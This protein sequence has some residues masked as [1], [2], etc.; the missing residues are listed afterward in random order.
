MM[1]S[2]LALAAAMTCGAPAPDG[3]M[4]LLYLECWPEMEIAGTAKPKPPAPARAADY[5]WPV[6]HVID[7]DTVAVDASA[8][9]PPELA[10]LKVRLRG[11]D[12]PETWR[13]KCEAERVAGEAATAFTERAVTGARAVL[14]RDPAWGKWG[15]RVIAE[16][17]L[18]GRA[19]S[20]ALIEAGHG[21]AY[22]GGRRQSWC[23]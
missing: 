17:V 8:D 5:A 12:T 4:T 3:A 2:A 20:A 9:M 18:D 6:V 14:V 15:G 1:L 11:V 22:D 21:R 13:P 7:G 19:L 10:D 16:L 23:H